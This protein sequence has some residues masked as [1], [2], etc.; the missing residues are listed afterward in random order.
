MRSSLSRS[1]S[2]ILSTGTPVQRETTGDVI[3]RDGLLDHPPPLAGGFGLGQ[4]L[5]KLR[6][7][8]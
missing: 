2:S 8:P 3:G 7:A 6:D 1:P 4:L 5:L